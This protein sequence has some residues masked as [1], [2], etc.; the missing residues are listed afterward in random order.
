[1]W[2]TGKLHRTTA[3][4]TLAA[5]L[6]RTVNCYPSIRGCIVIWRGDVLHAGGMAVPGTDNMRLFA[7]IVPKGAKIPKDSTY[8]DNY[9]SSRDQF[10]DDNSE[11]Y[12]M[13]GCT[14]KRDDVVERLDGFEVDLSLMD[15][16]T[17]D[18]S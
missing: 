15:G 12:A 6:T 8:L 16:V 7:Y 9:H 17:V 2:L 10:V 13:P 3:P 18:N 14:L 4:P 5:E 11:A 1:M